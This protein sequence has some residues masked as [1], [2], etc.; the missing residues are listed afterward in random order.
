MSFIAIIDLGSNSVR[1]S[2]AEINGS[3]YRTVYM[4]KNMI[5]LSENMNFDMTLKETAILRAVDA[6]N[7]FKGIANDFKCDKIITV[8][9]AAVRKAKNRKYFIDYIKE[10]VNVD[11][12]VIDGETEAKF[13]FYGVLE[14]TKHSDFIIM[15]IGGGSTEIIYSKNREIAAFDSV[16]FGSR[17]ISEEFLKDETPEKIFNAQKYVD[18]VI[19]QKKW[20]EG[21]NGLPVIGLGGCLRATVK[22]LCYMNETEFKNG[23][24]FSGEKVIDLYEKLK[25]ITVEERT[26]IDGIGTSR[27]DIILGGLIPY[28][29]V[30]EKTNVSELI[31]SESGIRDGILYTLCNGENIF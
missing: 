28:I 10:K 2:I 15:D 26:L 20:L 29:S 25:N 23:T 19:N 22:A 17:S 9:T 13:D 1:L 21:L 14:K 31:V 8:A 24:T 3:K 12:K 30:A 16:P 5:K 7:E 4:K 11:I 18:E 6:L 27:G